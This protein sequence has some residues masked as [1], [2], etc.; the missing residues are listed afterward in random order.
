MLKAITFDCWDTLIVDDHGCESK[1]KDY[2]HVILQERG[3]R[4]NR[5][6]LSDAFL[7][8]DRLRQEYVME[9]RK[10]KNALQRLATVLELLNVSLSHSEMAS[11]ADYC[12]KVILDFPP[13]D[14]PRVKELLASLT[15]DY[16]LAVICNTGWHSAQ[17]TKKLLAGHDLTKFFDFFSFSDEIGVAKP[18]PEIYK[19]TLEALECFPEEAVHVGDSEYSDIVGAKNAKMR[20]ILFTGVNDKYRDANTAD[21]MIDVYDNLLSILQC[22]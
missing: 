14:V 1:Q 17:T 5:D 10:T 4:L 8:E 3:F 15:K 12:D 19:I 6:D 2:L 20:A 7:R 11:V 18:H 22:M 16:R 21:I 9:K 13:P